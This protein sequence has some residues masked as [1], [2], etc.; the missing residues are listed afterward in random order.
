M[1]G[2]PSPAESGPLA[3]LAIAGDMTGLVFDGDEVDVFIKEESTSPAAD[4]DRSSRSK[5]GSPPIKFKTGGLTHR[6]ADSPTSSGSS[7]HRVAKRKTA[8]KVPHPSPHP[9]VPRRIEDWEPWKAVLHELYISQNRILRD[10]IQIMETN[11]NLKATPKMYK[12]QFARWGF[13]KYAV[14]RRPRIKT[15]IFVEHV[16]PEDDSPVAISPDAGTIY[17]I[18]SPLLYGNTDSRAVQSGLTAVGRFLQG[19]IEHDAANLQLEE[20]AGFVDPCYRYFKVAM[21]LFDQKENVVGGR[22]LRL[23]FLQIERKVSKPSMKSFSDLCILVPHL[24]IE[25]GRIDILS[26]YLRYLSRLATVKFGKHP[27]TEIVASFVEILDDPEEI[28]RYIMLLAQVNADTISSMPGVLDRTVEWASNQYLA[29]QR[30]ISPSPHTDQ[31]H[32]HHMLRLESQS[33]YWAQ[34]LIFQD[35]EANELAQQWMVRQF[36]DDFAARCEAL[37]EK[38]QERVAAGVMPLVF[39]RMMECLFVG[40]LS[41]YYETVE[42]WDKVFMY[43]K[44]G[45]ALSTDEQYVI[46]SLHLEGL[47]KNNGR[48]REAADLKKLRQELDWMESVRLQV[49]ML[50]M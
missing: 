41:D 37:L 1:D 2:S 34:K 11:Y 36:N 32:G 28:M 14:K 38:L 19:Y 13:F 27:V 26:A 29:C 40:W 48:P 22:V 12:N 46:W 10:I 44:R 9:V 39:S 24:L 8:I 42:D 25:S 6:I 49:D 3:L 16:G 33:V 43:S 45:L 23:A 31:R 35:P 20:V 7:Q 50:T 21:D 30:T 15:G 18:G 47:M 5:S 4:G 17:K